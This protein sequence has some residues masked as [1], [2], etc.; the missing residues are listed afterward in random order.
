MKTRKSIFASITV[1]FLAAAAFSFYLIRGR[2]QIISVSRTTV[3]MGTAV[4]LTLH[5]RK[6]IKTES[7]IR[8]KLNTEINQ[9]IDMID[10]L[11]E[12]VL[13]WRSEDSEVFRFNQTKDNEPFLIS[14]DLKQVLEES[15]ELSELAFGAIDITLRPMI[16]LWGIEEHDSS[17]PYIPPTEKEIQDIAAHI[18]ATHLQLSGNYLTKDDP[19]IQLDL[20]A[21]GK[22]FALDIALE[23]LLHSSEISGAVIAAGGS[24][25]VYGSKGDPYQIGI[26]DPNGSPNDYLGIVRIPEETGHSVFLST[27]G[28]Y[29]KFTE[30]NGKI[31]E[32]IINGRT[33]HPAESDLFSVTV[34]TEDNGLVSDALSTA[35][36]ILGADESMDLL[37]Q[38]HAEAI[39]VFRNGSILLTEGVKDSFS[40]TNPAYHIIN[41]LTEAQP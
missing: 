7:S 22:G 23:E 29:E 39:F 31:Y 37:N 27:S 24:V 35:C 38:Y 28:G 26:R 30:A 14:A 40:L 19:E 9:I 41:N 16:S 4:S 34:L 10:H 33:L 36:Y 17:K 1:I 3:E 13:S 32:H 6:G 21:V 2:S 12:S 11:D 15:L 5:G 25:L 18:G 8:E 20:G